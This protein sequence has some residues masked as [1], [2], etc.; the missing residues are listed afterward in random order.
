MNDSLLPSEFADLEPFAVTWCL[1]PEPER[2]AQR[3][4]STMAEMQAFYDAGFPRIEE[5][6]AYCDKFPLD[7]MP[8]EARRLLQLVYSIIMVAMCVEIWH[9]PRVIDGGDAKLHRVGGPLL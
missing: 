3:M 6:L 1:A 4:A 2:R 7:D 5:M 8:D 9:Q